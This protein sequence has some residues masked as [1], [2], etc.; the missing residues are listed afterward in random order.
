MLIYSAPQLSRSCVTTSRL[1]C[2]TLFA[3]ATLFP[4]LAVA[5]ATP[6]LSYQIIAERSHKN[7]LFTQGL[8]IDDGQIVESSGLYGKS[9]LVKYPLAEPESTWAKLTQ[10]FSFK[11]KISADHFAEGISILDDNLFLLTWQAGLLYVFDK[12]NFNYQKSLTYSGEGWGLTS[13]G[14]YLIRSDGSDKLYFHLP[15]DFSIAHSINVTVNGEAITQINELEFAQ[16]FIWANIWHDNHILKIDPKT[17]N[18]VGSIDLTPIVDSLKLKD[19]EAVL[20]GI[21]W[22]EQAQAFWI[23]GKLWPKL[24][25]LKFSTPQ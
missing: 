17:G 20:N 19:S 2:M 15:Q 18:V 23:T 11:Q 3:I 4:R 14:T 9:I 22:D 10:P 21:A 7:I 6:A 25:L 13:D 1:L 8:L 12:H 24:F 16:G 5:E